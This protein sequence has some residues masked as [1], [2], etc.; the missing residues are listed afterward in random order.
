MSQAWKVRS[1][2]YKARRALRSSQRA[3]PDKP[4]AEEEEFSLFD[5]SPWPATHDTWTCPCCSY[6]DN[7]FVQNKCGACGKEEP[8]TNTSPPRPS[9]IGHHT[10]AEAACS[11][12][13]QRT[14]EKLRAEV[15]LWEDT[16]K[17]LTTAH[18]KLLKAACPDQAVSVCL[19]KAQQPTVASSIDKTSVPALD[20]VLMSSHDTP[21]MWVP[22][23]DANPRAAEPNRTL[24]ISVP[25]AEAINPGEHEFQSQWVPSAEAVARGAEFDSLSHGTPVPT[26]KGHRT[27]NDTHTPTSTT[28]SHTNISNTRQTT[29]TEE[30]TGVSCCSYVS[31]ATS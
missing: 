29:H 9:A 31:A 1:Q 15:Q 20:S 2:A 28:H 11:L 5:N 16:V 23:S 30:F 12:S 19:L 21:P 22:R 25:S 13:E 24:V 14:K 8:E 27:F 17:E 6:H 4:R 3:Q 26:I 7:N 10:Y 18:R